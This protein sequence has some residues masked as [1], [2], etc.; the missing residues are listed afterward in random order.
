MLQEPGRRRC[1]RLPK[2]LAPYVFALYMATVMSLLMCLVI[3]IA[4][5]GFTDR[6]VEN[7][8]NAY[9]VAMPAAFACILLVRPIV[10]KLVALSVRSEG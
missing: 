9:R 3:T 4:E 2:P 7:V 5:F 1:R 8:M 6:Y 10:A